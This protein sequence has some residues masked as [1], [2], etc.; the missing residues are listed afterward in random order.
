MTRAFVIRPFDVKKNSRGVEVN[1]QAVHDLLIAPALRKAGILGDTVGE[2]I[3][4]GN[5]RKDMFA[6]IAEADLVVCDVTVHNANVFYEL[7]I[8]HALRRGHTIL[9]RG[10]GSAD[11]PPFDVLTDRFLTYDSDAPDKSVDQLAATIAAT[12][13]KLVKNDS[14]VF[15][16]LPQLSEA[17]AAALGEVP[18]D[19]NEEVARA[20]SSGMKGWLRLLAKEVGGMRFEWAALRS[21][22]RALWELQ[23]VD[24]AIDR[25]SHIADNHERTDVEANLALSNLFERKYR[26]DRNIQWLTRSDQAIERLNKSK[27]R[28]EQKAEV[29]ALEGRNAKTR[30]RV[31]LSGT[32]LEE[33]RKQAITAKLRESYEAYREAYLL[34]M[35]HYWS[36]I[37]A[38]QMAIIARSLS[39][40]AGWRRLFASDAKA[41]EYAM[42]LDEE[43]A[44]LRAS[45][46]LAVSDTSYSAGKKVDAWLAITRADLQFLFD[47]NPERVEQAYVDALTDRDAFAWGAARGQLALFAEL[48][49]HED[50]AEQVI[51]S[52]D[53]IVTPPGTPPRVVVFAGHRID[54]QGRESPRFPASSEERARTA[55][56][57]ALQRL[58]QES[59]S[60][61][62]LASAA[63]G[64]DI[65][66][67]ELC[68][69]L[70]IE[71][72]ICLPMPT[73][74]VA[75]L[76]YGV[77]DGWRNRFFKLVNSGK[78]L[79]L[80][81]QE[82]L[83][84]WLRSSD[85]DAWERGNVWT[86]E[87]ARS[88][89]LG[90]AT[91]LAL[92]DGKPDGDARGGTGHMVR[93]ARE[94]GSVKIEQIDAAVLVG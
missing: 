17:G 83:P 74:A 71:S 32:T 77:L 78:L 72:I 82:G 24:V 38:L 85:V 45:V 3:E 84:R 88:D 14:P 43:I 67:H 15:T 11:T 40:E 57:A 37:A 49:I 64:S 34:D 89:G 26:K 8:R 66:C 33:R 93:I 69:E 79:Q 58:Q 18:D 28:R 10:G 42:R 39:R 53:K 70:G 23:D 55:I 60:L 21:I 22:A 76:A 73:D 7:G 63:P 75:R 90:E 65:L 52:V 35:N 13:N 25:W 4:A 41:G 94:A 62:V 19:L 92:W 54:E 20:K 50:L 86:L 29:R 68:R 6:L 30:W 16:Y 31:G 61:R 48:G 12:R 59:P 2:I 44:G 5:I 46:S 80:S 47:D 91:L 56:R 87:M 81:D 27:L 9:I 1:F 36:G 51:R